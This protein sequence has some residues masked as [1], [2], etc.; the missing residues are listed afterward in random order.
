MNAPPPQEPNRHCLRPAKPHKKEA[1]KMKLCKL[2]GG[3][4]H[5][6]GTLGKLDWF[7]CRSCGMES[8]GNKVESENRS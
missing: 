3:I 1:G 4:L 8:S 6:L 2:C 5:Y 7:I